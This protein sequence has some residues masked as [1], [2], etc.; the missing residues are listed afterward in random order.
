MDRYIQIK[1]KA[2]LGNMVMIYRVASK[3]LEAE[4]TSRE[5]RFAILEDQSYVLPDTATESEKKRPK[6]S[7]NLYTR[8]NFQLLREFYIGTFRNDNF[9]FVLLSKGHIHETSPSQTRRYV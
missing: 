1:R 2:K 5:K 7:S 3:Q 4:N 9:H 8:E 6:S